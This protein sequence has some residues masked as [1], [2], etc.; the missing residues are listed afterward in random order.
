MHDVRE[1][2][3]AHELRHTDRP[4]FADTTDV[5]AAEIDQHDVLGTLLLVA[6]QLFGHPHVFFVGASARPRAGNRMRL[7]AGA[8]DAHQHLWRRP[9]HGYTARS[10]EIHVR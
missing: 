7:D 8:F 1:A 5:V 6:L 4:V 2:L 10:D 9:D 3:E